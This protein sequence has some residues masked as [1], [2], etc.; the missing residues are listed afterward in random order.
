MTDGYRLR[1]KL[2]SK[3]RHITLPEGFAAAGVACGIKA[4]G[5]K[6][7][8]IIAAGGD[9]AGAIIT[10][11][12]QIVGAP[13]TWCRKL[14][15]RG[16]GRVRGIVINSGYSNVCRGKRGL[17]DAQ[18]MA[19]LTARRLGC[20]PKRVLVASTGVIGRP[21]PMAKIRRGIE[22][23]ASR[24]GRSNDPAV[25]QAI[26]TTDTRPK[27]AAIQM[28]I[29]GRAVWLAG[30]IK[31]AG[32]IAPSLATMIAV[33]TTD[34]AV[35]PAALGKA[36]KSAADKSFNT[37]TIDSDTSTSD[38][39]AA[40][41]SGAAGNKPISTTSPA[42]RKFA[43]AMEELCMELAR[44]VVADG[45]GATKLITVRV[46]GARSGRDAEIAAKAVANSP[47]FKCAIHGGDPNWGRIAAALGKSAAKVA[48]ERLTIQIGGVKVFARGAGT[49]IDPKK[50]QRHLAG[51]EVQ[52]DCH[53]GLGKGGYTALTCDL[54]R[55]YVAINADYHT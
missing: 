13:I 43:A 24:L 54:S 23:A 34:A 36:L 55:D 42:Y 11:R 27:Y 4:S 20:S 51:P 32:M 3:I 49:K 44:Q 1:E 53:L 39:V 31:G 50:L 26:M 18:T 7:L 48:A 28:R 17:K 14:L 37:I 15:P 33:I 12:N 52:V 46:S 9:A 45:E 6:D 21:M 5:R 25:L 38:I 35:T 2:M 40:M 8:A 22:E 30:I 16:Y 19:Q 41:A 47:L 29:G 10:T